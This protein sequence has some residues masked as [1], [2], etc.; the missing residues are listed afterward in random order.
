MRIGIDIGGTFTDFA[1]LNDA[2]G[3]ISRHKCLT[4]QHDPAD[5]VIVG[6]QDLLRREGRSLQE[7]SMIFHGTTLV[8]NAIIE[9][10][11]AR[12]GLLVTQGFRDVLE[13]GRE[14]RYDIHD[15]LLPFP[16]PVVPRRWRRE[17][18][19]RISAKGEVLEGLNI[20]HARAQ[21][22]GLVQEGVEA[23]AVSF[24][25]SYRQP[26]HEQ[27]VASMLGEEFPQV[28]VST[29]AEVAPQ[30][31]E[32]E[33]TCT[34]VCN[35]YVR[36]LVDRY[37]ASLE[38]ELDLLGFEGRLLLMDSAGGLIS[39]TTARAL[40]VRLLESGPAAGATFSAYIGDLAGVSDLVAFDMGGTTAKTCLV[41]NGHPTRSDVLEVAR[42]ARFKPGSGLPVRTPVIE[43]IEIGAGGGSIAHLDQLGLLAVGPRSAGAFPGPACYG[44]GGDEPT[45]TDA[46]LCLGYL[47]PARFLGGAMRLDVGAAQKVL[48]QLDRALGL[49]VEVA[50]AVYRV[51]CEQMADAAR[52][53]LLERARD[54]RRL[55]L[56]AFGG[57]GPIHA[58]AVARRLGA[59]EVIVPS[60]CGVASAVGLLVAPVSFEFARS[61]PGVLAQ[62]DWGHVAEIY[63]D[64]RTD[65]VRA[66]TVAGADE[67]RL[68]F[69]HSV[70]LR[71]AGQSHDLTVPVPTVDGH[72]PERDAVLASFAEQYRAHYD[73]A[74]PNGDI[75]AMTWRLR[76][77]SA[78]P[79][80]HLRVSASPAARNS[81]A[82][83]AWFDEV[84]WMTAE[85]HQRA[86]LRHGQ[87][88]AG[89]AIIE[90]A[91]ST[92]VLPPRSR[93]T[94]D[95][96]GSLRI[97]LSRT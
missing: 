13:I 30:I 56:V 84:G 55:P 95:H 93:C 3:E 53:Y 28:A 1:L 96:L 45:V 63:D 62:L 65:A 26:A 81:S 49:D 97:D 64:L 10:R 40:P 27:S 22:W 19:E 35:A 33:R 16:V 71:I 61:S 6:L 23:I 8:T 67:G 82:R 15:L 2:E 21:A 50:G 48:A 54:P 88:I 89:P 52:T 90:E 76:G 42:M 73:S 74:L 46:C 39:T 57:A 7:C 51:V 4:S 92:T 85:V 59:N 41:L 86:G 9:R 79:S 31:G 60:W 14:Q 5:A 77:I 66:L 80:P 24:M 37:L 58:A 36:P 43:L 25:H 11:G 68:C 78:V 20:D 72:A 34:T 38:A 87:Q 32:Y 91:E 69:F 29:S 83:R 18:T 70:D 17:V 94:V 75:L 47:D 12:T 44:L